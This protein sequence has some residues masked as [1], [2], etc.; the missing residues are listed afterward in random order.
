[1][2]VDESCANFDNVM[3]SNNGRFNEA[4]ICR[5]GALGHRTEKQLGHARNTGRKVSTRNQEQLP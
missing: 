3:E 2:I 4:V 1:M 5:A